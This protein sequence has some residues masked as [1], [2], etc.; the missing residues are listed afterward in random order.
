MN[1]EQTE[2]LLELLKRLETV[3][4]REDY[5][6]CP[7]C[8]N[9]NNGSEDWHRKGCELKIFIDILKKENPLTYSEN[10]FP[11]NIDMERIREFKP[12]VFPN[13][14][15]YDPNITYF[16]PADEKMT[17][18]LYCSR[19]REEHINGDQCPVRLKNPRN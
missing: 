18:C 10:K 14:P 5:E 13:I 9:I 16:L 4:C 7:E 2:K 17:Y 12:F 8:G 11:V 19:T 15:K 1:K 6:V 3:I